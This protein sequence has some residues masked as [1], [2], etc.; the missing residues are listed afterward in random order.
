MRKRGVML[1]ISYYFF[2]YMVLK[3]S[4]CLGENLFS[5]YEVNILRVGFRGMCLNVILK[6]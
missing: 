2:I 3:E 1:F 4:Y 6:K 5:E